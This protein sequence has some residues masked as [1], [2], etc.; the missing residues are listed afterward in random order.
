M[1]PLFSCSNARRSSSSVQP[2]HNLISESR[3][4]RSTV[5][6]RPVRRRDGSEPSQTSMPPPSMEAVP[7][8]YP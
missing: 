7:R 4:H 8:R 6:S 5:Q 3:L 1:D 2:K